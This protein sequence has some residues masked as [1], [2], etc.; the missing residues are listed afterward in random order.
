MWKIIDE[1][2]HERVSPTV[3]MAQALFAII[4]NKR[5]AFSPEFVNVVAEFLSPF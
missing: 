1:R 4:G 3:I 5:P 2:G